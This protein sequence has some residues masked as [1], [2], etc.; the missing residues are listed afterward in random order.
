MI[1]L[2]FNEKTKEITR[3]VEEKQIVENS[4][5][6]LY[7]CSN[8][9]KKIGKKFIRIVSVVMERGSRERKF[10][11]AHHIFKIFNKRKKAGKK[12]TRRKFPLTGNFLNN[13]M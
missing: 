12:V 8:K 1:V 13:V 4:S 6:E 5:V 11:K 10:K 7:L 9:I 2:I 3:E